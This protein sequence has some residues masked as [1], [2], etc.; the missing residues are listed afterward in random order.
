MI[1]NK[2]DVPENMDAGSKL[3]FILDV[4]KRYDN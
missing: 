4:I 2:G 1:G 3:V